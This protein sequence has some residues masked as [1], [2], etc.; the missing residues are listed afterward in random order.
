MHSPGL[1]RYPGSGLPFHFEFVNRRFFFL[2][3]HA[4]ICTSK[5]GMSSLGLGGIKT[6]ER[7]MRHGDRASAMG[8][9]S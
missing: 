7:R 2:F 9:E 6:L 3:W 1:K 8:A 5:A 4:G